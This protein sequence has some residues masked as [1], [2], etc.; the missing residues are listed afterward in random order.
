MADA[1]TAEFPQNGNPLYAPNHV[2]RQLSTHT[3]EKDG[4]DVKIPEYPLSQSPVLKS[5]SE[6]ALSSQLGLTTQ[7]YEN[8]NVV[9]GTDHTDHCDSGFQRTSQSNK[10][11]LKSVGQDFSRQQ[12]QQNS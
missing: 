6:V 1:A 11:S 12:N 8:G 10:D 3:V 2:P 5:L 7:E 9:A 4:F